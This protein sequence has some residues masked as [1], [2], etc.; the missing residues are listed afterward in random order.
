M[1]DLLRLGLLQFGL[2]RR[3]IAFGYCCVAI[4]FSHVET[5][6]AA[7]PQTELVKPS[8][9]S[10]VNAYLRANSHFQSAIDEQ[11]IEVEQE[12]H[13]ESAAKGDGTNHARQVV[14]FV[15]RAF[16]Q[17]QYAAHQQV[18]KGF[19]HTTLAPFETLILPPAVDDQALASVRSALPEQVR[20]VVTWGESA[21][22]LVQSLGQEAPI[23]AA[24]LTAPVAGQENTEVQ[25]THQADPVVLIEKVIDLMPD[26]KTVHVVVDP[27]AAAWL[28]DYMHGALMRRGRELVVHKAGNLREAAQVYPK[29][30]LSINPAEEALWL[31]PNQPDGAEV[32]LPLILKSAWKRRIATFSNQVSH[33]E[34]GVLLGVTTNLLDH[35]GELASIE[36]IMHRNSLHPVS[37]KNAR[38]GLNIGDQHEQSGNVPTPFASRATRLA[39]NKRAA[40][41]LGIQLMPHHIEDIAVVMPL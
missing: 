23:L 39:I 20:S 7:S 17:A 16:S 41:R 3:I 34:K 19:E 28:I 30:L 31:S 11:A 21:L 4:A 29:V 25:I 18:A 9:S 26:I 5:L 32:F 14:F 12:R 27:Q 22:A 24:G 33:V 2:S 6:Y 36:N 38:S 35:G 8:T 13:K 10:H 40:A 15:S 1:P 37:L